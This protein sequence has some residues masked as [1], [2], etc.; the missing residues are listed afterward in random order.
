M[1]NSR[2]LLHG[3]GLVALSSLGLGSCGGDVGIVVSVE[4]WPSTSPYLLVDTQV[5]GTS[6]QQLRIPAG[7]NRFVVRLPSDQTGDLTL[8]AFA[9]DDTGCKVASGQ[10]SSTLSGGLRR[11]GEGTLTLSTLEP[12]L[13]KLSVR[14]NSGTGSVASTPPGLTCAGS[15]CDGE[16]TKNTNIHLAPTPGSYKQFSAWTGNC[17]GNNSCDIT[18]SRSIEISL[19]FMPRQCTP[20]G[21]CFHH[22][23]DASGKLIY[24]A[25]SILYWPSI[26]SHGVAWFF[27]NGGEVL[28]CD[29]NS[30]KR[31]LSILSTRS[32]NGTIPIR[33]DIWAMITTPKPALLR[34]SND[35]CK[36][37]YDFMS[38]DTCKSL[39]PSGPLF[40]GLQYVITTAQS[41]GGKNNSVIRISTNE[42]DQTRCGK[43]WD[44]GTVTI[45]SIYANGNIVWLMTDVPS[46]E[47][48]DC[49]S[50]PCTTSTASDI[51]AIFSYQFLSGNSKSA[52][53]ASN[54]YP[55]ATILVRCPVANAKCTPISIPYKTTDYIQSLVVGE[56]SSWIIGKNSSSSVGTDIISVNDQNSSSGLRINNAYSLSNFYAGW[57]NDTDLWMG[58][59]TNI[60]HCTASG[61]ETITPGF[62]TTYVYS[63]SGNGKDVW[64]GGY[65][66]EVLHYQQP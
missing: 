41:S 42:A 19:A 65:S 33:E 66:G 53:L 3:L 46:L 31:T 35:S 57:G 17:T 13:C 64:A 9:I 16:F 23:T 61:C 4:N 54:Q 49:S 62:G 44:T 37:S 40:S 51:P 30:C 38:N 36:I 34:C 5:N 2:A 48:L 26:D 27:G 50:F 22:P 24:E 45:N 25:T 11:T 6:G 55:T 14:I 28:R 20:Q 18:L 32:P 47:K 8:S 7:Q 39:V 56:N 52:W 63:I 59:D 21:W 58:V 60:R 29:V 15:I 10:L 12:A 1:W 43:L